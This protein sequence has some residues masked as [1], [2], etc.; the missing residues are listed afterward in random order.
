MVFVWQPSISEIF[1][2]SVAKNEQYIGLLLFI[3]IS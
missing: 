1:F 2:Y 3:N